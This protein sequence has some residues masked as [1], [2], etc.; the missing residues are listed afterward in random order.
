MLA[1][2]GQK[3]GCPKGVAPRKSVIWPTISLVKSRRLLI[4]LPVLSGLALVACGGGDSS[5]TTTVLAK[6]TIEVGYSDHPESRLITEIY[7]QALESAGFRVARKDTVLNREAGL[8]A[9]KSNEIQLYIDY[10]NDLLLNLDPSATPVP[11]TTTTSSTST[12]TTV[13]A[14]TTTSTA[15]TPTTAAATTTASSSSSTSTSSTTTTISELQK[16]LPAELVAGQV[17]GINVVPVIAC[18]LAEGSDLKTLS[19]VAA[20]DQELTLTAAEGFGATTLGVLGDRFTEVIT[21]T[22]DKIG[23]ALDAATTGCGVISSLSPAIAQFTLTVLQ[24][25]Q[26][27]QTPQLIVPVMTKVAA[28]PDVL[29]VIDSISISMNTELIAPLMKLMLVDGLI[30]EV[31][32]KDLLAAGQ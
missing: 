3:C 6:P 10:S 14:A 19:Q 30:A 13:A 24:D 1:S 26:G 29:S 21:L 28:T 9:L 15:T 18:K 17:S 22:E 11:A 31:V 12:S 8:A 2:N 4:A 25:D 5:P 27:L 23:A 20:A 7:A 16:Q 32:A